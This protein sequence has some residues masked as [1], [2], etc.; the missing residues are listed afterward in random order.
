MKKCNC[1][2]T[3]TDV[4]SEYIVPNANLFLK[5]NYVPLWF[6]YLISFLIVTFGTIM[7]YRSFDGFLMFFILLLL[8][9][10]S[11]SY[12]IAR[13]SRFVSKKVAR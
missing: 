5:N 11:V 9:T 3:K 1:M 4:E 6:W 2:Y 7:Y 12:R 8:A 10:F 13:Q